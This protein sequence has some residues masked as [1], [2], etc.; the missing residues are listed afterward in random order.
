LVKGLR[1]VR[2]IPRCIVLVLLSPRESPTGVMCPPLGS[3]ILVSGIRNGAAMGTQAERKIREVVFYTRLQI[4]YLR[5]LVRLAEIR[6]EHEAVVAQDSCSRAS[7]SGP[8]KPQ[9]VT[10]SPRASATSPEASP[11]D[12]SPLAGDLPQR[13]VV[14]IVGNPGFERYSAPPPWR[15]CRTRPS[16]GRAPSSMR[17]MKPQILPG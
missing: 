2:E 12:G 16:P 11:S 14:K 8:T 7:P 4:H 6:R 5:R 13:D 10:V 17:R 15:L 3:C 9:C 1:L